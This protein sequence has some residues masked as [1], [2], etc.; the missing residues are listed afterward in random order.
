MLKAYQSV[1]TIPVKISV[2]S[3]FLETRN[4]K[5]SKNPAVNYIFKAGDYPK[6]IRKLQLAVTGWRCLSGGLP[7][8]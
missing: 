2:V 7:T 5:Y 1:K 6:M 8:G 3:D 4:R